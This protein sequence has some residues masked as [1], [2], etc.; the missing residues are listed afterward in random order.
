MMSWNGEGREGKGMEWSGGGVAVFCF[1]LSFFFS[2]FQ[3]SR[4]GDGRRLSAG[5]IAEGEIER[6]VCCRM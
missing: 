1:S 5:V 3:T 6:A 2:F 4:F